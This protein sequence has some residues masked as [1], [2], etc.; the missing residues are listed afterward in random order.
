MCKRFFV[1]LV[2]A[3]AILPGLYANGQCNAPGNSAGC[4]KAEAGGCGAEAGGCKVVGCQE[5][6]VVGAAQVDRYLPLL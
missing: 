6:V 4:C 2:A 1:S 5:A 3:M